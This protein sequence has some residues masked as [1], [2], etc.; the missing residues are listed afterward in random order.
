MRGRSKQ[1]C[2]RLEID[3]VSLNAMGGRRMHIS[4]RS[5]D[6][7]E[8]IGI[9]FTFVAYFVIIYDAI[10][11]LLS[12][13]VMTGFG[14]GSDKIWNRRLMLL[15]AVSGL[16]LLLRLEVVNNTVSV[17]EDNTAKAA[18]KFINNARYMLSTASKAYYC[19]LILTTVGFY[20]MLPGLNKFQLL[21][22]SDI[23]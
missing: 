19:S 1:I 16:L 23:G 4:D 18:G 6:Y 8:T 12:G 10:L 22:L 21:S 13:L 2:D 3:K 5:C 7:I 14:I 17:H 20:L 15:K 11:L 9:S